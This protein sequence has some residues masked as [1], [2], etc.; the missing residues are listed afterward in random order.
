MGKLGARPRCTL[1]GMPRR[2]AVTILVLISLLAGAVALRLLIGEKGAFGWP[3]EPGLR[4]IRLER[5]CSGA[6]VGAALAVGGVLLQCL[7]RKPL[8]SPDLLGLASGSGFG[9]MLAAYGAYRAGL[10]IAPATSSVPAA[11]IGALA[12]L[13]LVYGLS[14]RRGLIEPVTLILVGVI[15]S[16]IFGA[17]TVFVQYLLPDRGIAAARWL[18]GALNDEN[19]W[20]RLGAVGG[21]TVAAVIAGALLAR[22]MDAASLSEDEARSL[23]VHLGAL[24]AVLFVLS[25]LLTAGAVVL[26][27]PIGFVGLVCPHAVRLSAGPAHRS[28]VVGSALAGS[29]PG[30][31]AGAFGEV[32][33]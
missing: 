3:D 5:V 1:L 9:V 32:L 13:G 2:A 16:I 10:G 6:I 22:Q 14:Q 18:L 19:T 33:G 23:G 12:A 28:L 8:A 21:I 25:G 15:I 27:G 20:A 7:L 4:Q 24:R 17:A 26:A 29:T 30:L 11:L 31:A